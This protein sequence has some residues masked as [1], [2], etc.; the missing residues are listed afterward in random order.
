MY[1]GG[2]VGGVPGGG[3]VGEVPGFQPGV[4]STPSSTVELSL[5]CSN[6]RNADFFSKS[7]PF[8]VIQIKVPKSQTWME[9]F[10]SETIQVQFYFIGFSFFS[11]SISIRKGS[12][13]KTPKTK[14]TITKRTMQQNTQ[15]D[16]R[17]N[18]KTPNITKRPNVSKR[19]K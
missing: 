16:K 7:D 12:G 6:L 10:R 11:G 15:C 14:R 9:I 4:S 5:S 19:P 3:V 18:Y 8:V 17:S 1:G 13:Y 2:V